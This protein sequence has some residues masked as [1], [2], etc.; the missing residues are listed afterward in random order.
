V[1]I[2]LSS[3]NAD[4]GISLPSKKKCIT[5]EIYGVKADL[6]RQKRSI[7]INHINPPYRK[8]KKNL[9]THLLSNRN[10]NVKKNEKLSRRNK[11]TDGNRNSK[12]GHR[13][14]T[15]SSREIIIKTSF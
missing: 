12:T 5:L 1:Y 7:N 9:G 15:V 3:S 2:Q 8:V 11:E 10:N 4:G 13:M 6:C 14:L